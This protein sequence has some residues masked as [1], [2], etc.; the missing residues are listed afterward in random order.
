MSPRND[1]G[2]DTGDGALPEVSGPVSILNA[3]VF[4]APLAPTSPGQLPLVTE[5]SAGRRWFRTDIDASPLRTPRHRSMPRDVALCRESDEGAGSRERRIDH[6]LDRVRMRPS[7]AAN[8]DFPADGHELGSA[9]IHDQ[10]RLTSRRSRTT[11]FRPNSETI[12]TAD[13]L[14]WDVM[15][16][17]RRSPPRTPMR[18]FR[19]RDSR[20]RVRRYRRPYGGDRV[21]DE[22]ASARAGARLTSKP[23][24]LSPL[25]VHLRTSWSGS[26]RSA[27]SRISGE[28][29]KSRRAVG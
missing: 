6:V 3:V 28:Q 9:W 14:P 29:Q 11:V 18:G 1:V 4:P 27:V 2:R 15:V 24:F 13:P 17:S 8:D 19:V 21:R 12:A 22:P 16:W 20:H 25:R 26:S 10:T 23:G 5:S 7:G